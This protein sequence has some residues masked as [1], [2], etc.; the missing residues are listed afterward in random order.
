MRSVD[1]IE[2]D[3]RLEKFLGVG[4][5]LD[6]ISLCQVLVRVGCSL[7]GGASAEKWRMLRS[8]TDN[9]LVLGSTD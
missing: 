6:G 1:G 9:K 3:G 7:I 2:V 4:G 8:I 5:Q